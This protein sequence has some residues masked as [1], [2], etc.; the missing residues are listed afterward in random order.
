MT[1]INWALDKDTEPDINKVC[2]VQACR[3]ISNGN[4]GE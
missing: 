3:A 1:V 4:M 2:A